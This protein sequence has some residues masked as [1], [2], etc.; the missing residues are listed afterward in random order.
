MVL[1]ETDL[2][3]KAAF[4]REPLPTHTRPSCADAVQA[5]TGQE[6]PQENKEAVLSSPAALNW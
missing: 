2:P 3:C 4:E 1:R 5:A 6:R